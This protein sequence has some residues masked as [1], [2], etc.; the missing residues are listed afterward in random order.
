MGFLDLFGLQEKPTSFQK[1]EAERDKMF[2][3]RYQKMAKQEPRE[4]PEAPRGRTKDDGKQY[5]S[6]LGKRDSEGFHRFD[7]YG[8]S[9][10]EFMNA[11]QT[12]KYRG[13]KISVRGSR[14]VEMALYTSFTIAVKIP[15]KDRVVR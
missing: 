1:R 5:G 2:S 15:K 3:E 6:P 9:A 4:Y 8:V 14:I 10:G 11:L 13:K 12:G 7:Y